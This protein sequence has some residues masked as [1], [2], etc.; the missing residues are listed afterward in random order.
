[1][2]LQMMVQLGQ[3]YQIIQF[4]YQVLQQHL[5]ILEVIK[6][7]LYH[8]VIIN[9]MFICGEQVVVVLVLVLEVQV[10]QV[11]WFKVFYL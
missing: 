6:H 5:H 10:V 7:I 3:K 1:M 2:N 11:L 9:Y 8:L 4:L